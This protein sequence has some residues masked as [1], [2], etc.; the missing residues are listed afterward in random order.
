VLF[1]HLAVVL[2]LAVTGDDPPKDPPAPTEDVEA[3]TGACLIDLPIVRAVCGDGD[4]DDGE[5]CDD[6]NAVSGDGCSSSCEI[7]DDVQPLRR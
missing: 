6:G 1:A 7:E 2:S 5:E 4:V 3:C